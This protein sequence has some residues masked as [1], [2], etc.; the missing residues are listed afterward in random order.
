MHFSVCLDDKFI[1][2]CW[3]YLSLILLCSQE[4]ML[5]STCNHL[6]LICFILH[7]RPC[8]LL[9]GILLSFLCPYLFSYNSFP[10]QTHLVASWNLQLLTAKII[11]PWKLWLL[12]KKYIHHANCRGRH[13]EKQLCNL[14]GNTK[15]RMAPQNARTT[16][17]LYSSWWLAVL[18]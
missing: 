12:R 3:W 5:K 9:P 10:S 11:T 1:F 7:T 15:S 4:L 2:F 8:R 14:A 18:L 17:S 13:F 6:I 16:N